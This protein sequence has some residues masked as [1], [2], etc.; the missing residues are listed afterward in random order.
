MLNS[1]SEYSL[2]Q[3]IG[4]MIITG[5]RGTTINEKS[6]VVKSIQEYHLGS[7]WLVD[8][9]GPM[10]ETIGNVESPAQLK[11]LTNNLQSYGNNSLLLAID[12]EGGEVI[13]LKEKHGFPQIPSAKYFGDLDNPQ[14]TST[15]AELVA[16]LLKEAGV[17]INFAPIVD[18]NSNP[19]CPVIGKRGRSF[20][21]DP[22]KVFIHAKEFI[23][24]HHEKNI[25][26]CLKHFPGHGSSLEDTHNGFVD[27]S[28]T[29][30]EAELVPYKILIAEGLVD[31][32][33]TAHIFNSNLDKKYPATLSKKII[34][35]LLRDKIGFDGVIFTDDLIM[36]AIDDHYTYEEAIELALNAG[37][38]IIVQGNAAKYNPDIVANT[39][40]TI[41]R[42]IESGKVTLERIDESFNRIIALKRRFGLAI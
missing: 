27:V 17:N 39:V 42:L 10:S 15:N 13:R 8:N 26:T 9:D 35:G 34:T 21:A 7:L 32:I 2:D 24:A 20:S 5:F 22:E 4:Q 41:K 14:L 40:E 33:M 29:W 28:R 31:S 38:D 30:S 16:S 25:A 37:I 19:E 12:A 1:N 6:V 3:K 36:K 23:S 11:T 18:V